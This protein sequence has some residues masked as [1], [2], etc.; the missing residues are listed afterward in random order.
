M[1]AQD[2][3]IG[4]RS[5]FGDGRTVWTIV[6]KRQLKSGKFKFKLVMSGKSFSGEATTKPLDPEYEVEVI[7]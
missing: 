4:M 3:R 6:A 1:M 7:P 5:T 2:L